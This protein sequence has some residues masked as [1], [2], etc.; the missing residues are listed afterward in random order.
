MLTVNEYYGGRVKSIRLQDREGL[1]TSGSMESG[2]VE[3][4]TSSRERMTVMTGSLTIRR[5]GDAAWATVRRG[6][7]FDV[8]AHVSF[9]VKADEPTAYLCRYG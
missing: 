3:F 1:L 4:S 7:S 5:P 2:E 9:H 6:E 8:P